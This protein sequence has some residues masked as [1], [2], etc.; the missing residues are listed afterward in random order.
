MKWALLKET[1]AM[2]TLLKLSYALKCY[3]LLKEKRACDAS[4]SSNYG[5]K[6]ISWS[7]CS[8][9]PLIF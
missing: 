2:L 3:L 1:E 9:E 4:E 8:V 6:T 7:L 5:A